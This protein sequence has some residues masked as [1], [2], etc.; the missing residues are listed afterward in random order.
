MPESSRWL[1]RHGKYEAMHDA[2]EDFGIEASIEDVK[3]TADQ[4]E[5]AAARQEHACEARS[6]FRPPVGYADGQGQPRARAVRPVPAQTSASAGFRGPDVAPR[7]RA[8]GDTGRG[9]PRK[10]GPRPRRAQATGAVRA[11]ALGA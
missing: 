1:L 8:R 3:Y 6:R 4:L 7:P 5:Q 9:R 2:L 10:G 11:T